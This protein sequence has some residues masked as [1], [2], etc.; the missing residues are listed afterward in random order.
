[1]N[2]KS[3]KLSS[4][5]SFSLKNCINDSV[6]IHNPNP[7]TLVEFSSVNSNAFDNSVF[8]ISIIPLHGS[9]FGMEIGITIASDKYHNTI[10]SFWFAIRPVNPFDFVTVEHVHDT[11]CIGM[12]QYSQR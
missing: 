9:L 8:K 12:V 1:M 5:G 4:S 10:D 7:T 3:S 2:Y 6:Y 11:K